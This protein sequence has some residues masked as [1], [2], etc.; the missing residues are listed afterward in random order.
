MAKAD[1]RSGSYSVRVSLT[2]P[3]TGERIQKRVTAGT[4]RELDAKVSDLKAQWNRGDYFEASKITVAEYLEKWLD[5]IRPT[6]RPASH[7]RYMRIV[8]KQIVPAMGTTMIGRLSP[9]QVQDFY[10]DLLTRQESPLSPSTVALYHGVLH[11]ALDQAV[12][13]RMLQRNVCDA[14]DAPRPR[15][16]EMQTWTAEQA[17]TFLA[18]VA[19]DDLAAFWCLA[20]YTGMRRGEM[21][22]LHWADIDLER[23]S[24]AVRRTLSR[25]ESGLVLGEPKT[26]AGRRS[27]ALPMPAVAALKAHRA[28]QLTRRLAFGAD[29][30]DNDLVF[31]RGD[32][33]ILHSNNVT[34]AFPRIVRRLNTTLPKDQHLPVIRLHDL[35]HTAATLMLANGEHPKVVQ[36]RLGHSDIA[37][38]LNRYSHVT[39]DMQ[40]EAADRLARLLGG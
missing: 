18:S 30:Q 13:W 12:K 3:L 25:G 35:R 5:A 6:I 34:H 19:H 7:D 15:N 21:L 2:D 31:E 33:S 24:L 4:K 10:A 9:V 17:R 39:M 27:I 28:R 23:G 32:G 26:K 8:R 29:W 38:T 36:E 22:A 37:M 11:K 40:R 1:K 20:L 16:P 14:V